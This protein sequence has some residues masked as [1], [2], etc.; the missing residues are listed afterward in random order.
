MFY[1]GM[2]VHHYEH[3]NF[4]DI[5]IRTT[6]HKHFDNNKDYKLPEREI[7]NILNE[8]LETYPIKINEKIKS[9]DDILDQILNI[10]IWN[11]IPTNYCIKDECMKHFKRVILNDVYH[12][13]ADMMN[14]N[15]SLELVRDSYKLSVKKA[16]TDHKDKYGLD[17]EKIE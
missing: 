10:K 2:Y 5:S 4:L 15:N 9:K 1:K 6:V 3:Q 7:K 14:R 8:H 16:L 11:G 17:R 13:Y 12:E